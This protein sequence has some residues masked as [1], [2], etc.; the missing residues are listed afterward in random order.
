[1][2]AIQIKKELG[3]RAAHLIQPGMVVG[4]GTGSTA[5]CFIHSLV[6]RVKSEKL[7]L[8]AVASSDRSA[9]LASAGGISILNL[10]EVS[11]IDITVDGAD[12][13]DSQKRLIKGAGG[14]LLREKI[15]AAASHQMVVI[16]DE[17]KLV[18]HLG[19]T[20]LPIEI[21]SYGALMTRRNIESF[22]HEGSWRLAQ[23]NQARPTFRLPHEPKEL[24]LTDNGHLIFDLIFS[25]PL[26]H[27]EQLH[28]QLKQIPGVLETGFFFHLAKKILIGYSDGRIEEIL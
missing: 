28:E 25:R 12:E 15:L 18:D 24:F 2:D 3:K 17:S 7:S 6:Q 20:K 22:G 14:A 16:A 26:H 27:P 23:L 9:E 10:N 8:K 1:V 21:L 19:Q 5:E 13:I 4:L 11:H